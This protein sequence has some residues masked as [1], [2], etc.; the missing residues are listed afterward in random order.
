M[1][2]GKLLMLTGYT[3]NGTA[4]RSI[5]I[6]FAGD[7]VVEGATLS[8][9]T[10]SVVPVAYVEQ[11]VFTNRSWGAAAGTVTIKTIS[12]DKIVVVLHDVRVE[13][14]EGDETV[15]TGAVTLN[16]TLTIANPSIS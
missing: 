6:D 8:V 14:A 4:S 5:A 2:S 3:V 13:H 11:D 1:S 7:D 16:G 12:S 10:R 9:A 15:S